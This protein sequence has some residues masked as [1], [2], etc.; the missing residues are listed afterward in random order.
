MI[1]TA[2]ELSRVDCANAIFDQIVA[3]SR[4]RIWSRLQPAPREIPIGL[5]GKTH[6]HLYKEILKV[7]GALEQQ[8][9]HDIQDFREIIAQ[10]K[11]L[12][13]HCRLLQN[14]S[15]NSNDEL[16]LLGEIVTQ[17]H[18]ISVN[19]GKSSLESHVVDKRFVFQDARWMC[20]IRQLDK[21][22]RYRGFCESA[23]EDSRRYPEMFK[24]IE[25]H[26]LN[27][28]KPARSLITGG[29][30]ARSHLH[31]HAEMQILAFYGLKSNAKLPKPRVIGVSRAACYLCNLFVQ[32]HEGFFVTKTHGRL[33]DAWNFPDLAET[34]PT[35]QDIYRE[36]I[37][38]MDSNMRNALV[39]ELRNPSRRQN[40]I[41]SWPALP[42]PTISSP[43]ASTI[44]SQVPEEA[45]NGFIETAFPDSHSSLTAKQNTTP[46]IPTIPPLNAPSEDPDPGIESI[47]QVPPPDSP[48]P[49][50]FSS[51]P[52]PQPSHFSLATIG[53]AR[54]NHPPAPIPSPI[55]PSPSPPTTSPRLPPS[56]LPLLSPTLPTTHTI[57]PT[58]PFHTRI[59]NISTTF[60]IEPNAK[61]TVTIDDTTNHSHSTD[62]ERISATAQPIDVM[63]MEAGTGLVF[64]RAGGVDGV[65]LDL[66]FGGRGRRV[67]LKWVEG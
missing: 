66:K 4:R 12:S 26:T 39:R 15:R 67:E 17:S 54:S 13:E 37:A 27:P 62:N 21:I 64:E 6:Q 1:F 34:D 25:L 45:E 10:L 24:H 41:G 18:N 20:C 16:L 33:F 22:G 38:R 7:V 55:P 23:A 2:A 59:A 40:P 3:L 28:Y 31:V 30:A 9:I 48:P 60:E 35:Q 53:P 43:V 47:T 65:V 57:T 52:S 56:S 61:G 32:R 58:S 36:T 11:V 8:M 42:L 63:Q 19:G 14:C 49:S 51:N 44:L 29:Q 5:S 50:P 46:P